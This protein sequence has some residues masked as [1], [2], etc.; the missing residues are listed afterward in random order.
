[1]CPDWLQIAGFTP[2]PREKSSSDT[3][4]EC[5]HSKLETHKFWLPSE[6]L[7]SECLEGFVR[8]FNTTVSMAVPRSVWLLSS[9]SQE[10]EVTLG[11][12]MSQALCKWTEDK[13]FVCSYQET[14]E[15]FWTQLFLL[16]SQP[17]ALHHDLPTERERCFQF[18]QCTLPI[19]I[20][21]CFLKASRCLYSSALVD[22][23]SIHC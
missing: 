14:L 21:N 7:V 5:L 8:W 20:M 3:G 16:F 17:P 9:D 23:V 19:H 1:M 6:C 10:E 13:S 4:N 2:I 11:Q 18:T 22:V 15:P 12:A